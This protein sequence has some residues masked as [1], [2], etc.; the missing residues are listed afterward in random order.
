MI[1]LIQLQ[2]E[3][4]ALKAVLIGRGPQRET[5]QRQCEE[6]KLDVQFT[7]EIPHEEV[8]GLMR[9]SK[10]L[11]HPAVYESYGF[12]FTEAL[13]CGMSIVSHAV[14]I[15]KAGPHWTLVDSTEQF[16]PAIKQ[17]L[18]DFDPNQQP[19]FDRIETTINQ[20]LEL[21]EGDE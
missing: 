10:V 16:V 17:A 3:G 20:Y 9:K 7:G 19:E 12:V 15:A 14:G 4:I 18:A 1:L 11:L 21:Y 8:L 5:L 13:A 6:A 2:S